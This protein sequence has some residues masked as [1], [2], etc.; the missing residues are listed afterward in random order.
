MISLGNKLNEMFIAGVTGDIEY[1]DEIVE[2]AMGCQCCLL[3]EQPCCVI[4]VYDMIDLSYHGIH[5]YV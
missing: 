5:N 2:E 3:G 4:W 1:R